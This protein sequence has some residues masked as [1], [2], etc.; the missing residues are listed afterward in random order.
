MKEVASSS[1]FTYQDV[2]CFIVLSCI[3]WSCTGSGTGA[4]VGLT[5]V[6]APYCA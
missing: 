1:P 2:P 4:G 6:L 5:L 3:V